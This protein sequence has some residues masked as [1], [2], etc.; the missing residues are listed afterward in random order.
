MTLV[1]IAAWQVRS[2]SAPIQAKE[3]MGFALKIAGTPK[4]ERSRRVLE[5]AK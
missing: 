1:P 5:A 2:M 4:E 3:N